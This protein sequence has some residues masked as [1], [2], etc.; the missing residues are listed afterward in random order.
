MI[1]ELF[2]GLAFAIGQTTDPATLPIAPVQVVA[3]ASASVPAPVRALPKASVPAPASIPVL[4]ASTIPQASAGAYDERAFLPPTPTQQ[5]GSP[6][7]FLTTSPS[8][9]CND[10]GGKHGGGFISQFCDAYRDEFFPKEKDKGQNGNGEPEEPKAEPARRAL[11]APFASPPFPTGEWQGFPLIGVPPSDA[12]YPLMKAIY[13][14]P[15]GDEIKDSRV[16]ASGWINASGTWSTSKNSNTPASYWV[17]PNSLVADQLLFRLEREVD[18]VQT[19]HI[20]V[21][22]RSTVFYGIDYRYTMAGGWGSDQLL[23]HNLLYGFDPTEQYVNVYIPGIGKGM[24]ITAGRWIATPDI[25]TQFAPDNYMGSHSLLF[26]VD[27]YTET[28]VMATVMLNDQ[29][30]VQAAIHAGADMAPWYAGAVPTGMFGVRW[31]SKD[32]KDSIYTVLNAINNAE[33]QYFDLRGVPAGHHN[34]NIFQS[35]WQHKFNDCVHTKTEAYIMWERNAAVG[36]TPSIGPFQFNSG[37]GLGPTIP[38]TSLTYAILNYTMFKV[39]DKDFFTVRN[40]WTKDEH[41]TRYGFPG[42][43]TSNSIGWSHNVNS[44]FQIRP[45]IGYYRNWNVPAFDNGARQNQLLYGF[46]MT[47]RF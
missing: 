47:L 9:N 29:W 44:L 3:Q 10:C 27:V 25:E 19:D 4:S 38:G 22:F 24:I 7:P 32:N 37:G 20:D 26:T 8:A 17:K 31:V 21:G 12:V 41:G 1:P 14:G 13:G 18:S 5:N 36:G 40:E 42:N 39:T 2:L 6:C 35:T 43:Y 28:G 34:Y 11:P 45:E 46:D 33:F 30:T 16:K 15:W 23:V